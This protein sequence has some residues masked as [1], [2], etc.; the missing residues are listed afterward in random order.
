MQQD[1]MLMF[2]SCGWFFDEISGLETVQCLQYAARAIAPGPAVPPRLRAGVR[3][4]AGRRAEQPAPVRRRPGRLGPGRPARG[5]R[6]R[7]RPGA[8]R[9]QPDLP[10]ADGERSAGAR[11][12]LSTWRSSTR[13]SAR[14]GSGHLAVGRLRAR[15][16]RTWNEAETCFVVVHFGGLDFHAVLSHGLEPGRVSRRSR[17]ELLATYRAGSLADVTT[18]VAQRVPRQGPPARRPVQGRA[19][20]DH[21]HRPGRTGSRTTSGRSSSWP[22]RTRRCSTAWA[23]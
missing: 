11:L 3:R 6:P 17:L 16:R 2:T 5:R 10:A 4:D 14:R 12:L 1:A 9:H 22:T 8:P 21:R 15:S 7:P 13:R 23:S 18:L 19:A 20:A